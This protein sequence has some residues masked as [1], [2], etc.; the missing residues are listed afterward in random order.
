MSKI[1]PG[2]R[3]KQIKIKSNAA[4][5]VFIPTIPKINSNI[6]TTSEINPIAFLLIAI[7]ITL[8]VSS[9]EICVYY[10]YNV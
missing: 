10:I 6:P 5:L 2:T 3:N 4:G 1:A 8:F 9:L 7:K